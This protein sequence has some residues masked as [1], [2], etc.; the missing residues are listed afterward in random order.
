MIGIEHSVG[1]YHD[2]WKVKSGLGG[3]GIVTVTATWLSKTG[4]N[5]R[6][7]LNLGANSKID[8]RIRGWLSNRGLNK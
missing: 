4:G 8:R 2:H 5:Q 6:S 3:I 1:K 7:K